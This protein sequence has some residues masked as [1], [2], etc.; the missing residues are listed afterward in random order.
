MDKK[1]FIDAIAIIGD[2]DYIEYSDLDEEDV[3]LFE[4]AVIQYAKD[5]KPLRDKYAEY[6]SDK[7]M[8][9]RFASAAIK[10]LENFVEE[11]GHLYPN[12]DDD[13]LTF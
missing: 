8:G 11:D 10:G 1:K 7:I 5:L 13:G 3:E 9:I 6:I 12:D 2:I 4:K